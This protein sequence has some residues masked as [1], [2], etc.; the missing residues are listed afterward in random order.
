MENP[1]FSKIIITVFALFLGFT[2]FSQNYVP[3][4][5]SNP[6]TF[7]MDVKGDIVLIGNNILGPSNNAFNNNFAYNNSVNMQY[8]DIDSDAST[9]SSSSADLT[10]PNQDCYR[11]IRADLYWAAVNPGDQ[12]ITDVKLKGPTGGYNDITGTIIY[13]AGANSTDGGNSFSYAC[14][15]NVTDIVTTFGSISDLGTYTVANVSSAVGRSSDVGNGTG[16][17]AGWS[18]FI[19]YEDPTL[20]GKSITSFDGFSAI[21]LAQNSFA[22][23][24][25]SGFRTVPAPTPVRANFAFATLEGD[26]RITGDRLL[27]NG[28]PLSTVDRNQD[29]FFNSTITQLSGLPVNDR[30]PN[31][32]NTL[33]FDTGILAVPNPSNSVIANNATSAVVRLE[34]NGDTYFPYFFALAVDIIEPNIVLTKTVEDDSG[35]DISGQT[36]DLGDSLNYVIGFQNTGNDN[37]TSFQIRDILPVNITFNYPS[38][39]VLPAGVTVA[40]YDPVTRELVFDI[41]NYLVEEND[42]V[43]EIRIE[44]SVVDACNQLADA[45]SNIINNQAYANYAGTLN[46][47]FEITDDPSL[48]SNVGCLFVPQATNFLAELD[49]TFV[50]N[51]VLCGATLELTAADGY[52][53]Y[54]WST[55]DTGSPV[56]GTGQSITVDQTGTYYVYNTAIAPCQSIT[57]EFIVELFGG[58][59]ENPVIPYADEVVTCPNNGKLL[60]NIFLCGINDSTLIETNITGASSIIWEQLDE[61]SCTAVSNT[62]CAN[63]DNSCVWDEVETGSDYLANTSGQFR[64]TINYAGGCFVQFYFNVYQN[65]L[66][67]T[68]ASTDIICTTDGSITVNNVPSGYEYSLDGINY[69]NSNVFSVD[70]AGLYTVYIVQTGIATNPCVFTVP[71]IQIRERDFTVTSTIL[72]PLCNGDKGTIQLAANDVDPQY[73]YTLSTGGTVVNSVGPILE[74]TYSFDNLNPGTY[75]ATVTTENGCTYTEDVII[76]EPPLLT[77]TAAIT[78]PLTCNDGEITIY[79]QG[80]TAPYF[81]FVNSTTDFQTVPEIVVTAAGTYNITVVDSNNCV[82][83][84]TITMDDI[85]DPEYN[86]T[87]TDILCYNDT[88]GEIQINVTN[89]NGYTLE[90]SI[91][92]GV[93]YSPN[94]TFSNL[95]GGDYPVIIKYTLAGSECLTTV[96][97]ITIDQP[98]EALTATAGISALAGCGPS[99]EGTIRITNPQGGTPFPAPNLYEYSFDNQA[100]WITSNESFVSPGSYTVY[101]RDANGCIFAMQDTILDQEPPAP[102]IDIGDTLFNCDGSGN[103]TVTIT[104]NGGSNYTYDYYIDGTLNPNTTDPQTFTNVPTGSHTVSVEYSL[105]DVPT[106]SNLLY[107]TFGYGQNTTSPGINTTYYCFEHQIAPGACNG[108]TH[109]NDGEYSVTSDIVNPFGTW[110]DPVDHTPATTPPTQDGRFLVVNIG[111]SIPVT[112]ILYEKQI[113]DIIPNQP[114]QVE[115]AALNLLRVGTSGFDPNL[116]VELIDAGGNVIDSYNTGDIPKTNNW[117][118]YPTTPAT[119]DPGANTS[120]TFILR[121]N[122]QQNGG[123][124]VAIDDI[125]VFQLPEACSTTVEFPFVIASGNAFTADITGTSMVTCSGDSDGEITIAAQNF[126]TTLGYQYSTD[127][128]LTWITQMTSPYT[129]TGLTDDT[130]EVIIRYDDSVDTCEF[131]FTETITAP[132]PLTISLTN[133]EVTC[134]D[135]ATITASATEGTPGYSF[136]LIDTVAPFTTTNFVNGVVTDVVPGTYTVEVTDAG[137]C[138]ESTT[139]TLDAPIAPTATISTA[140]DFCF[141]PVSGATIEV[142]ASGG[143]TPYQYN[144]NGGAFQDE[145]DFT[146]LTPGTYT[147]IVR[148]AF[149]CEVTLAAETIQPELVLNAVI[150]KD[151]DC[152]ATPDAEITGTITG[153]LAPFT[154]AVSENGSPYTDL[155][156]T[157]S[158]F[159]YAIPTAGTYQFQ[160][161]DAQGCTAESG[162][163]TIDAISTPTGTAD[164][165][166][167]LCFDDANGEIQLFAADGAGGYT[168]SFNGG[169]F[170]TTSLFTGLDA[171]TTTATTT[172]YTYQIQ[173]SNSC[174]SPVYT[175]TLNNPTEIVA[176]ATLSNNTNCSTTTDITVAASGGTG[177][178]TY[179]FNGSTAYTATNILTVTNTA[180]T[181]TITYSVRDGNGCIDTET[182]DI[183]PYNPLTGMTFADANI[184]TCNDT[185]T[186]VTVTPTDGIAPFIF[187]ITAPASETSNVSGVST[188][189]F[190]NLAPGNY[191]FQITDANGCTISAS[192]NIAPA[193]NIAVADTNTDQ[194]CFG[195]DDGTATFTMTDVSSLGN[196]TY[197]LTPNAGTITQTGNDVTVTDLPAGSYTFD[198]IDTATGCS[199]SASITI[200]PTTQITFT[201]TGSNVNCNTDDSNIT[202]TTLSGG[203]GIYTY[204]YVTSGSTAPI[205]TDYSTST[206]VDTSVLGLII[207]VYVMDSNNCVVMDTVTIIRDDLPTVTA[208]VD[209]QCTGTGNN[210]TITATATGIATLMYS[211]DGTNFQTGNT[212]TVTPG[213]YTITVRDGNGCIVTDTV[214]VNPQ[215][216]L[217][218]VLD[219][220]ITCVLPQEAQITLTATGGDTT[221]TY[222]YSTDGG[223]T[224]TTMPTNVLNTTTP[225]S[226]IFMVT[227]ASSCTVVT[228]TPIEIT[229]AVNPDIT[230]VQTGFINCNG[231]ETGAIS[232]TPDTTVGQAPYVFEVFNTT[233]STSYGSQT[234]GLPAGDYTVTV[235]DARGC[236][237]IELITISEPTP[238]VLDF[239]VTPITCSASG[240]SLGEIIINSVTGGTANYTYHVTGVNGYDQELLN[241]DGATQ[242]FEVVDFGI[243]EIIITDSNG[244]TFLEQ[245]ILVASPPDD[246]DINIAATILDCAAGGQADVS[247]GSSSS[248]TGVGPFYFAIYTGPGMTWDGIPTGSTTWQLGTGVPVSTTFIGLLPDVTYTFVVYD[249]DTKCYYFETATTPIP[250]NSTLTVDSVVSN[251]ITC[252]GSAD[253]NVSFTINNTQTGPIDVTY[254]IFDSLT[255]ATTGVTGSGTVPASGSLPVSNLGPLAFG[256]YFVTITETSGTNANCGITTDPFNI[257]ESAILFNLT[258]SVSSNENCN[259]LGVITGIASDGTAPYQYQIL[260]ESATA[261]DATSTAWASSNTF[262]VVA[263]DYTVYAIDAY[264]CIRDFDV[265]LVRD[266]EP[267]ID[268]Q[269]SP[270]FVGNPINIT[271]TGAVTIGSPLYSMNGTTFVSSPDFTVASAGTYTLYIQDGNGCVASTPYLVNDQV[272]LSADLTKALDCTAS[273]NAEI[274]LTASGGDSTSYT[275]EVSTDGGT[276]FTP[277]ATNVYSAATAGTYDFMV[278]DAAG[279][280]STATQVVD[281]IVPTT[282]TTV[283]T[284]VSCNGGSDGTITVTTT[285]AT[286]P[287]MYQLD[288]GTPQSSNVFTGLS[289]GTSYIVTVIDAISCSYASAPITITEPIVLTATE[290]LSAITN[291]NVATVITV[292]GQD[293]TPTGSGEYYYSFNGSGFTTNNTFTVNNN[294]SVQT[295]NYIVRDANGCEVTGS[296]TVDPL[297]PPTDLDFSAT[298]ITCLVSTSDITLTA[299]GGVLALSYE[300][301]SPA[302]ATTNTT[303]AST[304]IFT[305][306]PVDNYTFQVTDANGCSYQELYVLQDVENIEV[307]GQLISDVTCNPGNDGEVTFTV[308]N[309][310]GTYSYSINSGPTVTGQTS[311]TVSVTGLTA[312]STQTILI[313]DETTGCTT[314]TFVDVAQATPLDLVLDTNVNANCNDGAQVSVTASG[315]TGS[316][317]Y[318]FVVSG[319]PAGTYSS[320]NSA[321][322]DPAISTTWDVHVQDTNNCVITTPLT[323]TIDTDPIPT[324]ITVA[325]SQCISG[326]NDYSFTVSVATGIA[327]YEYSIGNGFQSSPDFTV[328]AAGTYTITVRDANGCTD[329]VTYTIDDPIALTLAA[330][331]PSCSDDDGEITVTGI[332]GTGSYTYALSPNPGS[333]SLTGNVF[334]GV[335]SG[336][337]VVTITDLATACTNDAT[338]VLDVATPVTFTATATDVTCNGE[339]NGVIT[340]DLPATNDNPIYTYEITAPIVV[341]PQNSNIFTGLAAGTYTVQVNSGKGCFAT[342]NVIIAEPN[343]IVVSAPTVSQYEC[344]TD[345]NTINYAS[346]TVNTVT[347]GSGTYTIYEFVESGTVVQSG[348]SNVYTESDASGGTYTVNVYDDQGCLGTTATT[349]VINPYIDLDTITVT[350]D[351]AITCTNLEDITVTASGTNGTP[352]NLEYTVEDVTG[353][354]TGGVYSQT[355]TT[356]VFTGLDV[357][358]YI[359]S[360]TNLDSICTLQDVHYVNNPNTFDLVIDSVVDVTC[361][362][363]NDGSVNVTFIDDVVSATNPDQSGPFDYTVL[364]SAGTTVTSGTTATAGPI[365]ITGLVGGTYTINATLTGNPFCTV[366]KNFTITRPTAALALTTTQTSVTCLDNMGTISAV[367]TGGWGNLEYELTGTANVPYST[368]GEFTD[369]SA[370]NYTVNVRDSQGCIVSE[371]IILAL[372]TPIAATF[373][374]N[375]TLLSCFGDQDASITVT[376][377]TGGQ[378]ANYTYTL[379]SSSPSVSNSGPQLSNVFTDLGAGT[380]SVTIE[381][382]FN[383]TMTSV[384]IVINQP[385]EIDASLVNSST[386][387]CPIAYQLTL[388]ATGGTGIYTYSDT[389]NFSNVLGTFTTSVV[390]PV[391]PGTYQ[392]Y[393]RDANGCVSIVSNEITIDVLPDLEL[394]LTSDN[395]T[396]N[397]FGDNSGTITASAQGGLGNYSYTLEDSLGNTIEVTTDNPAN[398]TDLIAGTYTVTVLSNNCIMDSDSITITEPDSALQVTFAATDITCSGDDDGQLVITATGGTGIIKY[399]ISPQLNQFFETNVFENLEAGTYTFIAQD[400]LGCYY[401]DTFTIE[402]PEPVLIQIVSG[403]LLPETCEGE[404]NG[405]FSI[406]ISGGSLPYSVVLDDYNGTYTTGTATQTVFDF[407]NLNGGDHTLFIRDAV[408]CESEWNITFP[409]SVRIDPVAVVEYLCDGN[410]LS[411]TV[412]VTVDESITDFSLLQFSLDGVGSQASNIFTNVDYAN[413]AD[414]YVE[415]THANGCV[416][417]TEFFTIEDYQP[418]A[419]ILVES[420]EPGGFIAETTG[421]TGDYTYTLNDI[422]YGSQNEYVVTEAGNYT[423]VVTDS[424]GCQ[425][426]ARINIELVGPCISNYFTPNN[427]GVVDTWAPGCVE[428]FPDLTFDIF[429]R[430]G[431]KIATYRVGEYWD[432]KYNGTELPTGDYWYVVKTNSTLLDK[433]YVGHFTL[434]R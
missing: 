135:G 179:S 4:V 293:G 149:G 217:A 266:A 86:I 138:T 262:N 311:A 132:N 148:D 226:Y 314:T 205:A 416:Q 239:T 110:L 181:Q 333:V 396:I 346:I 104:N 279:C 237:E 230:V 384:D 206:T 378:G 28:T 318:S 76:I 202:Y 375:A 5:D 243:Y 97:T 81:Y 299:T 414:H 44:A 246:L 209:N 61:T 127:N 421:G 359:I 143:V 52:D 25:I 128:G 307:I 19:V 220:D 394:T 322:L 349:V 208:A 345:T 185:T 62:D 334:S 17:S 332:N 324:G 327:P 400:V 294:G 37:A 429:D 170:T 120:L 222:E 423:V 306:L 71:D 57:Q 210:Y 395:P 123:N 390:I 77:V 192:H 367:G 240:V 316:Y 272:L 347:G 244:C 55:S 218:A 376:N 290:S 254:E 303:G 420:D 203:T 34:T 231:E 43:Y 403:S 154:Y 51:E 152:T 22:E 291:C 42:P 14:H 54:S 58:S 39:L 287:F 344:T 297:D 215:L 433:E 90:Y 224:Y 204:A 160:V 223:A 426:E 103:A 26:K 228:T 241:Q 12:P 30:V 187:E 401:T 348:A 295:V 101:I 23:I 300:I 238:I 276:T 121:S 177:T 2:S 374:P 373:T 387:P 7:D 190:T 111:S 410:I 174:V 60:P 59:L 424:A 1:T 328:N 141:D 178:Y 381:D 92:N 256:N 330:I 377:V 248:I 312:A 140:S 336:T 313:T 9:F 339:S 83:T 175:I 409:E 184:I 326:T 283:E 68:V 430:Y 353:S 249:D 151:L 49:C 161:T 216:T 20:T 166:D 406:E 112:A 310:T 50:Q 96:E 275:Y 321:I 355:N 270:C 207:D 93:T 418:I 402:D 197:T 133:T 47:D 105:L 411:N 85:P 98:D 139:L 119:L 194:V 419:L 75:T 225:G 343:I 363:D 399:A 335:P 108:T 15:A 167:P 252:T 354:V 432:G 142:T 41:A 428:D 337:Y 198:V 130:Y 48:N 302:S 134:L 408:G 136:Q 286:G 385:T 352:T 87:H 398:F 369:L 33:G 164:G 24:P 89:A 393:V 242:V 212:F 329:T 165:I 182:I 11:I 267:T 67:A 36:I 150:T 296:V 45:C 144:I 107:E 88:T 309:F 417:Y 221:Y 109:I 113:N 356:G 146:N 325:G 157:G 53:S 361:F 317:S 171:N 285:S 340:V 169:A 82:A 84:T 40:S 21:S 124:D 229:P 413:G 382:G 251:N 308:S 425:A 397:C 370:G 301:L 94:P 305:G 274:T 118:E 282:F 158:P 351:N 211:I 323:I 117:I 431:R 258:A 100:T 360:V 422:N 412:T 366:T 99:G 247:I 405:A 38:G 95:S 155:G 268:A 233:T 338:V 172:D 227:D 232:I 116:V 386:Q 281:A 8:I 56:I 35:N 235:T 31:S 129:I 415:V 269:T 250:T 80:G 176:T 147:I 288:G 200:D 6:P 368:N 125:R 319:T 137:G 261:P 392:Y 78:S 271:I 219:K 264:G 162:I 3:F 131:P 122:V 10:I 284:N 191:T 106:F 265:T 407:T 315:G 320:S 236:T 159:T 73:F 186:A 362:N 27:L 389:S 16:Q 46:P 331:S 201:A 64:L 273:P 245:N 364:D 383:C 388:S 372:P 115:F 74:N 32:T 277:M 434:Y 365:T 63:E 257:T 126:D 404:A 70:T 298:P 391:T 69:Q 260:L 72:Q 358:N 213:T 379:N 380:Y 341:A 263:D 91:D 18:L 371:N 357:A 156:A 342:E 114:I 350:V 29:N 13:E 280:E 255:L 196:Y 278:T 195:S 188:G 145:N 65:L 193:V 183:P 173:D 259:D 189:V 102:T 214:T 153:G 163:N 180:T 199:T 79:P 168:F 292:L 66:E 289:Q 253:G 427:D 234:S 304:G